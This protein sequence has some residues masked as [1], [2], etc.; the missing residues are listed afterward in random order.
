VW[1]NLSDPEFADK[2][3]RVYKEHIDFGSTGKAFLKS[4]K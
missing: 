3:A 4:I 2:S 1:I